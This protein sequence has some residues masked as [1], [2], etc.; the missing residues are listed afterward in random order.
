MHPVALAA[1]LAAG[2]ALAAAPVAPATN[3][4]NLAPVFS[5]VPAGER[6]MT[7]TLPPERVARELRILPRIGAVYGASLD[8]GR[9][10]LHLDFD[11]E[12]MHITADPEHSVE[13]METLLVALEARRLEVLPEWECPAEEL[14]DGRVR[15]YLSHTYEEAA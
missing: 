14:E 2:A 8:E 13:T 15:I 12:D 10:E 1:S 5:S 9:I 3:P 11:E 6:A 4:A 7:L